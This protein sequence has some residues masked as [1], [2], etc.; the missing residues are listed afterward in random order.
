MQTLFNIWS[1][2]F[3]LMI[4]FIAALDKY[5]EIRPSV[6]IAAIWPIT[7]ALIP[8]FGMLHYIRIKTGWHTDCKF[9][10]KA[11]NYRKSTNS[12]V[13]K[14]F[15]ITIFWCELQFWKTRG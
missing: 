10:A 5:S 7:I 14:G 4:V 8:Y 3:V 11:F 2:G 15:A 9:S 6:L 13:I 12:N 1:I